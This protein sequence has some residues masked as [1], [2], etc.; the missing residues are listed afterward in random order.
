MRVLLQNLG[1]QL[2]RLGSLGSSQQMC[3]VWERGKASAKS[4][5]NKLR[6]GQLR[7]WRREP[8]SGA[9]EGT[10]FF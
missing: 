2:L 4:C 9:E 6:G 7:V 1:L 5:R 3:T 8:G 10:L